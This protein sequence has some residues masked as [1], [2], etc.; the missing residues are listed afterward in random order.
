MGQN[1]SQVDR[2]ASHFPD[3]DYFVLPR[4]TQDFATWSVA[5]VRELHRRFQKIVYGFGMN[6]SQFDSLLSINPPPGVTINTLFSAIDTDQDGR[7][8]ALKFFGGVALCCNGQFEEK[9]R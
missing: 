1:L 3:W 8:D 6:E 9:A 7:I 2:N 4:E 5:D